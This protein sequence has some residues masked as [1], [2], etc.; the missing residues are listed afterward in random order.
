MFYFFED[1]QAVQKVTELYNNQKDANLRLE[2]EVELLGGEVA[3][4]NQTI[5]QL[6]GQFKDVQE[7]K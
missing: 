2:S 5:K 3:R 4:L 1:G 7:K 6:K